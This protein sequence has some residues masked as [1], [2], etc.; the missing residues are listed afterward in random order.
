MRKRFR[1]IMRHFWNRMMMSIFFSARIG[2]LFNDAIEVSFESFKKGVS[3]LTFFDAFERPPNTPRCCCFFDDARAR[4]FE[5]SVCVCVCLF[6]RVFFLPQ[7]SPLFLVT[8]FS[9]LYTF[10]S[11]QH[12]HGGTPG[13]HLRDGEGPRELP[14]LLQG[15]RGPKRRLCSRGDLFFVMCV[16]VVF[17]RVESNRIELEIDPH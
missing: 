1:F 16:L 11:H 5:R 6:L 12:H 4:P 17:S 7:N 14:V 2:V 9:P 15:K 3:R 13:E 8:K 10:V